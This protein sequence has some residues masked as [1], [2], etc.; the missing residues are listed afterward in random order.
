MAVKTERAMSGV[1]WS[2]RQEQ[3]ESGIRVREREER[4]M[5]R[6]YRPK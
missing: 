2:D 1:G 3:Y 4:F 6:V 5:T